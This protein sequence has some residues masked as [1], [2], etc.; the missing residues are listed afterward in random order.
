MRTCLRYCEARRR[1]A[2]RVMKIERRPARAP[3]RSP[4]AEMHAEQHAPAQ[5]KGRRPF[6]QGALPGEIV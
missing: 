5:S 3:K 6:A 2:A 4:N 1:R